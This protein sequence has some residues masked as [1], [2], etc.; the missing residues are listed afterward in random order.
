M[1]LYDVTS[2]ATTPNCSTSTAINIFWFD[3][4]KKIGPGLSVLGKEEVQ[5]AVGW[6]F[7]YLVLQHLTNGLN[8]VITTLFDIGTKNISLQSQMTMS[9]ASFF[10]ESFLFIFHYHF[11]VIFTTLFDTG[12]KNISLRSQMTMS[13]AS[14]FLQSFLYAQWSRRH[15]EPS[16]RSLTLSP[17]LPGT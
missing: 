3:F 12:T 14:F 15:Q 7:Q 2:I 9:G 8:V 13:G 16:H 1:Y 10:L 11:F 17:N 4:E 6:I 5:V